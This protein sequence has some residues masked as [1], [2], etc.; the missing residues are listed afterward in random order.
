MSGAS[1]ITRRYSTT[2]RERNYDLTLQDNSASTLSA[3]GEPARYLSGSISSAESDPMPTSVIF[4]APFY[5]RSYIATS[6]ASSPGI[7]VASGVSLRIVSF[8]LASSARQMAQ[9][10]SAAQAQPEKP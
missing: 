7:L 5:S 6:K 9:T 3:T 4:P 2:V 8:G 10:R 1:Y